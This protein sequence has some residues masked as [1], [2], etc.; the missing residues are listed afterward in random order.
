M[1]ILAALP[2]EQREQ[3]IG[4]LPVHEQN[5]W[6]E[7]ERRSG[8][9]QVGREAGLEEGRAA[10]IELIFNLLG[11]RNVEVDPDSE[12]KIRTCEDLPTLQRWVRRSFRATSVAEL[13]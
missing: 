13:F 3:L 2:K 12:T 6:L 4:E 10:L 5:T 1:T 11:E 9:Y 8:T 7:V